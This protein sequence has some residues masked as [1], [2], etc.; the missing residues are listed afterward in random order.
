MILCEKA[1]IRAQWCLRAWIR[2]QIGS[3]F[4]IRI[5]IQCLDPNH[6]SLH[7]FYVIFGFSVVGNPAYQK[8]SESLSGLSLISPIRTYRFHKA[9]SNLTNARQT[10]NH[11]FVGQ[12]QTQLT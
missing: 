1:R 12:T 5:Q 11:N 2:I 9:Y 10:L 6:C 3:I 8:S 4:R 7:F